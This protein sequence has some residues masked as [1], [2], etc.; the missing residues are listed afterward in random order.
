MM[1]CLTKLR[2]NQNTARENS[3]GSQTSNRPPDDKRHRVWSGG[4]DQRANLK[5]DDS[6]QIDNF[7][8]KQCVEF[9][10]KQL[11]ATEGEEVCVGPPAKVLGGVEIIADNRNRGGEDGLVLALRLER[12]Q[13]A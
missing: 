9:A 1:G 7:D 4:A 11:E 3:S 2:Q 6:Y 5:Y 12:A 8:R 10:I 13:W